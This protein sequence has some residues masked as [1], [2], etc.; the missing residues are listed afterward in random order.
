MCYSTWRATSQDGVGWEV[1]GGSSSPS[2]LPRG[3][4]CLRRLPSTPGVPW[5][6]N[7]GVSWNS[8]P[9]PL[10]VPTPRGRFSGASLQRGHCWSPVKGYVH[11]PV[12]RGQG[13]QNPHCDKQPVWSACPQGLAGTLSCFPCW[14]SCLAPGAGETLET[15]TPPSVLP[16]TPPRLASQVPP[17][18]SPAPLDCRPPVSK[19]PRH[20]SVVSSCLCPRGLA[21]NTKSFSGILTG[22]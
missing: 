2:G 9:P 18:A 20:R 15:P 14:T 11:S 3:L 6:H 19:T 22:L 17:L 16:G 10:P 7:E 21:S 8:L 1:L 5:F 12:L 4:I 13:Y